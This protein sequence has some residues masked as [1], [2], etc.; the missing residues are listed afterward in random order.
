MLTA[1]RDPA[2]RFKRDVLVLGE[3]PASR[4]LSAGFVCARDLCACTLFRPTH[5]PTP[6]HPGVV[7]CCEQLYVHVWCGRRDGSRRP[8]L[9]S[10]DMS[11]PVRTPSYRDDDPDLLLAIALSKSL[12]AR[13][14]LEQ[15][16]RLSTNHSTGCCRRSMLCTTRTSLSLLCQPR[17]TPSQT[18]NRMSTMPTSAH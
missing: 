4:G 18:M 10:P 2:D 8:W 5:D 15:A 16:S 17:R 6:P 11:Y 1:R 7:R 3:S 14:R 12:M 9:P 13:P